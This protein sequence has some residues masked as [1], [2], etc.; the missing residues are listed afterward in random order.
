MQSSILYIIIRDRPFQIN[1]APKSDLKPK[2]KI[3][4]W[5][6]SKFD[7]SKYKIV[8]KNKLLYVLLIDNFLRIFPSPKISLK[9]HINYIPEKILII[10]V[11][12]IGD[13]ILSTPAIE[14]IRKSFPNSKLVLLT[15]PLAA[16]LL[17]ENNDVD[18]T[19]PFTPFW[20][21]KENPF[22]LFFEY[23]RILGLLRKYKFDLAIDFRGDIRNIFLFLYLCGAKFRVS[24]AIGGGGKLLTDIVPY[25]GL[26]HKMEFHNDIARFIGCDPIKELKIVQ[27]E[28]EKDF[29]RKRIKKEEGLL[30]LGIH[31][32]ARMPLKCY[33][34]EKF[35]EALNL[36]LKEYRVKLYILCG[37]SDRERGMIIHRAMKESEVEVIKDL[38]IRELASCI[39]ELDLFLCNDSAPMHI[40]STFNIPTIAVFG[41]SDS[42]ETGP[43]GK[44]SR[45]IEIPLDCR[46]GCD[47]SSCFNTS[48]HACMKMINPEEIAKTF[49]SLK[50]LL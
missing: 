49:S 1:Y 44:F 12:Y 5:I 16:E 14:S 35:A 33:P 29:A 28:P 20:F 3:T 40:A 30:T 7:T 48:Y 50:K 26:K 45:V 41:P 8:N 6:I 27:N 21:Y 32:G 43:L 47:E 37:D 23:I 17:K 9:E 24:Y 2:N 18:E 31:P 15:N 19:I 34:S 36:I 39:S 25:S 22:K 38:S 42:R 13:V 10:R 11:A 46:S 4:D